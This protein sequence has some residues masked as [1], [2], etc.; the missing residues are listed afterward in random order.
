MKTCVNEFQNSTIPE[1]IASIGSD[2]AV[3]KSFVDPDLT[4]RAL[5]ESEISYFKGEGAAFFDIIFTASLP[6]RSPVKVR[7]N[8]EAQNRYNPGYD[9]VS[10]GIF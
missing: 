10:R 3:G 5:T 6:G 9:L 7:I 1:I 4:N 2:L 8:V